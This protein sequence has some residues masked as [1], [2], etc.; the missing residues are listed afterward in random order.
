[1]LELLDVLDRLG[2]LLLGER[3]D[4]PE[5]LAP[6]LQ[7]LDATREVGALGVGQ[8]LA[9][10]LGLESEPAGQPLELRARVAVPVAR[11]LRLH[12]GAR[13][14]LAAGLQACLD[15]DLLL[16]AGAQLGGEALARVAVG[17][18]L[19]VE[20]LHARVRCA[21]GRCERGG[22]PLGGGPQALV[23]G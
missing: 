16:R 23:V 11:L 6:A 15:A 13:D 9:G 1:M 20:R 4:G 7:A 19:G 2:V 8:R 14:L 12:L 10:G 18:Q 3:V 21:L 5:L 17:D 22:E